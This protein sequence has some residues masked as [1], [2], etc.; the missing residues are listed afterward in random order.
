[1]GR[2]NEEGN[3][4]VKMAEVLLYMHKYGIL[5]SVE[6]ILRRRVGEKGE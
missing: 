2:V 5:Q 1:M 3:R 4:R 6:V